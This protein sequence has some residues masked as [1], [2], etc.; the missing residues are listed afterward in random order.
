[1]N[2]C[3]KVK[4]LDLPEGSYLVV[5]SSV[6]AV[7]GIRES[8]DIDISVSYDVFRKLWEEGWKAEQ[9]VD[10]PHTVLRKDVFDVGINWHGKPTE[11]WLD[12]VTYIEG[13]PFLSLQDLKAWKLDHARPKD[14]RDVELIDSY[15]KNSSK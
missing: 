9:S 14:I 7:H 11:A 3:E 15:L 4:S 1:M 12:R 2:I 5:G 8:D 10:L 13:V 6:M